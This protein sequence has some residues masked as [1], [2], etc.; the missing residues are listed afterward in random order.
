[1]LAPKNNNRI[2]VGLSCL[3]TSV[4]DLIGCKLTYGEQ[5]LCS[6]C[7]KHLNRLEAPENPKDDTR[8]WA[9]LLNWAALPSRPHVSKY[10]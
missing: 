4:T 10:T 3:A 8:W 2:E 9:H 7:L 1:M 6:V 5:R